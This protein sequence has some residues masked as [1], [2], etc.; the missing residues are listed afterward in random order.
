MSREILQL[1]RKQLTTRSPADELVDFLLGRSNAE[2]TP[3]MAE[4]L[5]RLHVCADLIRKYGSKKKV[6]EAMVN[7]MRLM[8]DD[9]YSLATAYRDFDD[10]TRVFG[11]TPLTSRQ[12]YID[13]VMEKLYETRR[14]AKEAGNLKALVAADA[15]IMRAISEYFGDAQGIDWNVVQ[16]APRIIG[17]MPEELAVKLPDDWRQEVAN[18]VKRRRSTHLDADDAEIVE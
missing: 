4:L 7:H 1:R 13:D 11:T 9:E 15:N 8:K 17:F 5:A 10:A 16:P 2:P 3:K 18:I 6:A 12:F 14:I